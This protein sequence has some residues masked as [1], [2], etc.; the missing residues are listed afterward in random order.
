[1]IETNC[2][3]NELPVNHCNS[4]EV[5]SSLNASFKIHAVSE[6]VVYTPAEF[7]YSRAMVMT[8]RVQSIQFSV[9]AC[10]D[11]ML[12]LSLVPGITSTSTYEVVLGTA[13]NTKCEIRKAGVPNAVASVSAAVLS[14]SEDRFVK[15]VSF[16]LH[17]GSRTA[18]NVG[19]RSTIT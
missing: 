14:C 18:V 6:Y 12:A 11:A 17:Y 16:T 10:N 1:M 2:V 19:L 4:V 15:N 5:S 8:T 9:H 13:Q 3:L 7:N